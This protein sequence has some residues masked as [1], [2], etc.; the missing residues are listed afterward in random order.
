MR[1]DIAMPEHGGAAAEVTAQR[2]ALR[3][4]WRWIAPWIL[5]AVLIIVFLLGLV[6]ASGA[7]DD[8]TYWIGLIAAVLALAVLIWLLRAALDGDEWPSLF[9]EEPEPLIILIALLTILAVIGSVLAAR[10]ESVAVSGTGYALGAVSILLIFF[11]L[12]HYFDCR[13][14]L[15]PAADEAGRLP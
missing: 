4:I 3:E 5:A 10:G 12:K 15:H 13:E 7:A 14:A 11:N 1:E 8:G 2:V 9:V 6:G